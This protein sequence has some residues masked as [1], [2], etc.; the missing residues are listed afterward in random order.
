MRIPDFR[1]KKLCV[2][3]L[4]GKVM[5]VVKAIQKMQMDMKKLSEEKMKNRIR[6]YDNNLDEEE[7]DELI[8]DPEVA[9][10]Y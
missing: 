10:S 7:L 4:Q 8:R 9:L 1:F 5:R 3:A 2:T 6:M